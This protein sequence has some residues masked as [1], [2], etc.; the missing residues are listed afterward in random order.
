MSFFGPEEKPGALQRGVITEK[1][2]ALL[3]DECNQCRGGDGCADPVTFDDFL[4][5]S[6]VP[7]STTVLRAPGT[8]NCFTAD[9]LHAHYDQTVAQGQPFYEPTSRQPLSPLDEWIKAN[10]QGTQKLPDKARKDPAKYFHAEMGRA[11]DLARDGMTGSAVVLYVRAAPCLQW[12][13]STSF[14]QDLYDALREFQMFDV[15]DSYRNLVVR[16]A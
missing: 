9:S 6:D 5:P 2:R 12:M 15:A 4:D 13:P 16:F 10:A 3:R 1:N 14:D 8:G 7:D 11:L